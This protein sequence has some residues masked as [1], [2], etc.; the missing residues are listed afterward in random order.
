MMNAGKATKLLWK[1]FFEMTADQQC[2][3]MARDLVLIEQG[4][5]SSET[6]RASSPPLPIYQPRF[7]GSSR[8]PTAETRGGQ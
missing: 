1:Q 5:V 3:E 6:M 7:I 4:M 8:K 2:L